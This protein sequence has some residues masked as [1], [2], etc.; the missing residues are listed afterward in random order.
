MDT[1]AGAAGMLAVR[2]S[3]AITVGSQPGRQDAT[4]GICGGRLK[5]SR[6][7]KLA[8]LGLCACSAVATVLLLRPMLATPGGTPAA[9]ALRVVEWYIRRVSLAGIIFYPLLRLVPMSV[10]S[11]VGRARHLLAAWLL[12][13]LIF[14]LATSLFA[15]EQLGDWTEPQRSSLVFRLAWTLWLV[16]QALLLYGAVPLIFRSWQKRFGPAPSPSPP[17]SSL[18]QPLGILIIAFNLVSGLLRLWM[19]LDVLPWLLLSAPAACVVRVL[20]R[21]SRFAHSWPHVLLLSA[22][23]AVTAAVPS[24]ML[25]GLAAAGEA[26]QL[27]LLTVY[28]ICMSFTLRIVRETAAAAIDRHTSFALG[29][30][31]D[32]FDHFFIELLFLLVEP[33]DVLFFAFWAMSFTRS[34]LRNS[35]Y[36]ADIADWILCVER[37]EHERLG[38]LQELVIDK[39]TVTFIKRS[40][41]VIVPLVIVTDTLAEG[42]GVASISHGTRVNTGVML[43]GYGYIFLTQEVSIWFASRLLNWR[44]NHARAKV[45]PVGLSSDGAALPA[46]IVEAEP[47][48]S[49]EEMGEAEEGGEEAIESEASPTSAAKVSQL[50]SAFG[51]PSG[52]TGPPV[53][54]PPVAGPPVAGP[55]GSPSAAFTKPGTRPPKLPALAT[56]SS[57]TAWMRAG[58]KVESRALK[59]K[60][61]LSLTSSLTLLQYKTAEVLTWEAHA[62]ITD[63]WQE[64]FWYFVCVACF[65]CATA[66]DAVAW[67]RRGWTL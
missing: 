54:G 4:K 31:I 55:P 32:F 30:P 53:A 25:S 14:L 15:P 10:R 61:K 19:A 41:A 37:A 5:S 2:A 33:F 17:A 42:I 39:D 66:I 34:I 62:S 50:R 46:A 16:A 43:A 20:D 60:R 9:I 40:V 49:D 35:G 45:K 51:S 47:H 13:D 57:R 1:R 21:R 8:V 26:L 44:I 27:V 52:K 36:I 22:L 58:I 38:R 48:S 65:S 12:C 7:L 24:A 18:A 67:I 3:M 6:S 23:T 64:H 56:G 63:Y 28:F 11:S 59:A 29:M